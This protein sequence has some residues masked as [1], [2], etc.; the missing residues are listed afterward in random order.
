MQQKKKYYRWT[1]LLG[2]KTESQV[3][4]F[5]QLHKAWQVWDMN[6]SHIQLPKLI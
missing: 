4:Y 6:L 5:A 2:E 1:H 3:K